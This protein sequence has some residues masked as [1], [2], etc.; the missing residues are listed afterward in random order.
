MYIAQIKA[1]SFFKGSQS[2]RRTGSFFKGSYLACEENRHVKPH[3]ISGAR[4][5]LSATE[6]LDDNLPST[7]LLILSTFSSSERHPPPPS[8]S[9]SS[10][11]RHPWPTST[12]QQRSSVAKND[13]NHINHSPSSPT[14]PSPPPPLLL[15]DIL[16]PRSTSQPKSSV[17]ENQFAVHIPLPLLFLSSTAPCLKYLHSEEEGG[18][19][20]KK[21]LS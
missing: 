15:K 1:D 17:A 14:P 4:R 20:A 3:G 6:A 16:W 8:P 9:S 19:G 5:L 12:L 10:P 11:E 2:F 21:C 13:H 7:T 18:G